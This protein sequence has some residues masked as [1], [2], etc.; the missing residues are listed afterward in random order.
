MADKKTN[1]IDAPKLR[2]LLS[3]LIIV[4]ICAAAGAF[5]F[6]R[7]QLE[8]Y[9]LQ[10]QKA[11][12]DAQVSSNDIAKLE[13]LKQELEDNQVAVARAKSIV[14][15]SQHYQYQN[16]I[17]DDITTYAQKAGV[18]ISGISFDSDAAAGAGSV[19]AP[20][21]QS[22]TTTGLK[23]VS[24]TLSLKN[25]TNYAA[26]IRFMHYIEANLTKMQILD[27]G[28]S[29]IANDP[30]NITVEHISLEVYTR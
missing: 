12:A 19:A 28:F 2:I 25:P 1:G 26:V 11:N 30:V 9:A 18:T 17:V 15:D 10:V 21:A 16:Q 3:L 14:A 22:T 6:F 23:A 13:S 4:I 5:W 7:Q 29:R 8:S 24:V 20:A 27:V